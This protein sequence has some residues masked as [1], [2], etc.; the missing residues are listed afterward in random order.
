MSH[1]G[2]KA[3]MTHLSLVY[4]LARDTG[5]FLSTLLAI[6]LLA[7]RPTLPALL[8]MVLAGARLILY[9]RLQFKWDHC[10]FVQRVDSRKKTSK[11]GIKFNFFT[12][13]NS[14]TLILLTNIADQKR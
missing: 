14:F 3:I 11:L 1:D 5:L 13:F 7:E 9:Y 8:G 6:A 12:L 10:R 4:P 2:I